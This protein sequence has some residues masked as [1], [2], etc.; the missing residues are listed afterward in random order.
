MSNDLAAR[1]AAAQLTGLSRVRTVVPAP[2]F[3]G[4][5]KPGAPAFTNYA[6]AQNPGEPVTELGDSLDTLRAA[7]PPGP[8][9]FELI[10]EAC[11]GA[12][13]ALEAA[14]LTVVGRYPLLTLEVAD[15]RMPPTPEGATVEVA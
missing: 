14:G 9:R 15:L 8:V 3:A 13:A 2:P 7:F 11:P 10:D 6:V 5:I 12:V 1:I 4:L